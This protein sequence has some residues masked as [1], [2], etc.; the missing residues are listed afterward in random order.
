MSYKQMRLVLFFDLPMETVSQQRDYRNF[1]KKMKS[2]G[3]YMIQKSVYVKM[4]IDQ[5]VAES[6]IA[7]VK[8]E[9]PKDGNIFVL[10][11]TE[12]QFA[13]ME[14]LLGDYTTDVVND[15]RRIIEL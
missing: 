2:Q 6:A 8:T 9:L 7:K 11:V 4:G 10:R 13:S 14:F 15:D 12:K 3:F 1:M 5:Q